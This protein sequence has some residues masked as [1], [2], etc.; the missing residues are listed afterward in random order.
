[1]K[2]KLLALILTLTMALAAQVTAHAEEYFDIIDGY[3]EI[4]YGEGA[5]V[6]PDEVTE[7]APGAF[8]GAPLTELTVP[9][10]VKTI[11]QEAF[12]DCTQLTSVT[13]S[14]GVET[15]GE[16]AFSGCTS[17]TSVTIPDSVTTIEDGAF[18]GCTSLTDVTLPDRLL[19]NCNDFLGDTPWAATTLTEQAGIQAGADFVLEGY[20]LV[21]YVGEGGDVVI[22]DGVQ[23]IGED[24][25]KECTL[26]TGVTFPDSLVSIGDGAFDRC[27]RLTE[28]TIPDNITEIGSSAF[29]YCTGLTDVTFSQNLETIGG[30]AFEGCSSLTSLTIP[31]G[32]ID[33]LAFLDCTGLTDVMLGDGVTYIGRASFKDCYNLTNVTFGNGITRINE[34]AFAGTKLTTMV[35]RDGLEYVESM[36]FPT[37]L[38][39]LALPASVTTMSTEALDNSPNVTVHV[40]PGSET[41]IFILRRGLTPEGDYEEFVQQAD[42]AAA[43]SEV[44]EM[45]AEEVETASEEETAPAEESSGGMGGAIAVV[46]VVVL[47]AGGAYVILKKKKA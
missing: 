1:M 7:I 11:G 4:G 13:L 19:A 38:Q 35:L 18:E 34:E 47:A 9:G 22:P 12:A 17:L 39:D 28:V 10:S 42:S 14:P 46:I 15:L 44:E 30:R 40:V 24:A 2:R 23:S 21:D 5:V 16:G 32:S 26:L 41:E 45:P 25:F 6:I 27:I 43:G 8:Y 3:L 36:A 20:Q 31:S 37:T 29:F 33:G